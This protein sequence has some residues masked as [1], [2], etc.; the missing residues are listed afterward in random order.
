MDRIEQRMRQLRVSNGS[1]VWDDLEGML[2]AN[3]PTKFRMPDIER[4]T[5]I[6][7]PRIHLRLYSTMMRAHRLDESQMITLFPLSLSGAASRWFASLESSRRRTWDDLAQEFL[8][9]FSF[10]TVVDVSRRELEALRQRIDESP[11][12]QLP[13]THPSY[14]PHRY[15]PR[16][17]CPTYDQTYMPQTLRPSVSYSAT[18]QPC[19]AA[20]FIARPTSPYPRPRR[21][22]SQL[23]M[24][25]SQTLWKLTEARLLTALTSRPPPQPIPPQFRMDLHYAYHQG[26]RHETDRCTILRHP[27]VTMNP[28]PAHIT[29]AVPPPADNMHSIDFVEFD[30]HIHMLSW[31]DYELEPIVLDEIYEMSGVTLGPRMPVPFILPLIFPHYSVQMPFVFIPDVDEVQAPYVDDVHTSDEEVRREDDEILKQFLL[32]SSS[33][34]RDALIRA[35]SQIRVETTTIPEGLIHVV[36]VGRATCIVFFDD[37]LPAEGSSHTRSLYIS[38]GCSGRRAPSI[39]LDNCSVLNVCPLAIAI[40]LGYAPSDFGPSTQTVRAYYNTR[41]EVRL[42]LLSYSRFLRIPSSFN[43]LLGRLWIHRAG[44]IPSSL[45]QKVKFIHDG[46]VVTV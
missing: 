6:G 5:G 2:V 16:A 3:F 36:T 15:R 22:F 12:L 45:H 29:H 19:Y 34:H 30:D 1:A 27:S 13:G 4:Y 43:L 26:P 44:A 8:R 11:V 25:L 31:D 18:G 20:Q 41:R 46:Q 38:I 40:A 28:L 10:N 9:Q 42:H 24:L 32:A 37:D 21:Q 14:A 17:L 23:G 33:I 7:C 39:L 35:L